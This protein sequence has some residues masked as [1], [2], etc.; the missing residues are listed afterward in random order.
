M[1]ATLTLLPVRKKQG[2]PSLHFSSEGDWRMR[3]CVEGGGDG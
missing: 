2:V 3:T 1:V